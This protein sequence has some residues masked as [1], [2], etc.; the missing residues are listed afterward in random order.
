MGNINVN[1][2]AINA[3]CGIIRQVGMTPG[4]AGKFFTISTK[5]ALK[6]YDKLK[7][8]SSVA[9]APDLFVNRP[10]PT[11][12]IK[13]HVVLS[14][15][16]RTDAT[17]NCKVVFNPGT[18]EEAS[19]TVVAGGIGFGI[20][21]EDAIK[22]A[23]GPNGKNTI[24]ADGKKLL[25]ET[26]DLIDGQI[27]WIDALVGR[28]QKAKQSLE[29]SK[30]DNATKINEYYAALKATTPEVMTVNSGDTAEIHIESAE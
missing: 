7:E 5:H 23:L 4:L 25:K 1:M 11:F 27:A 3:N 29:T 30:R 6:D 18:D 20:P 28:L 10:I 16:V 26:D 8:S 13:S 19:A 15:E 22:K 2:D 14:Q 9:G 12:D 17:G 21:T 24:F